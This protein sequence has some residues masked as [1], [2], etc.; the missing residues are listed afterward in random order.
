MP[1]ARF[2]VTG[3]EQPRY[4]RIAARDGGETHS[5]LLDG[6]KEGEGKAYFRLAGIDHSTDHSRGLWGYDDKGSE[7]LHAAGPRS[8]DRRG[9]GR[10]DREHRRRRRLGAGRQELLLYACWTK[11]TGRRRS[12]TT[13]SARRSREDRLVYEEEDPG[14]FMGVGGSLLDDFIYI[15][16]HDHETSEYRLLSTTDLTAEPQAGRR[17]ARPAS[18][19]R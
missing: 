14:F 15:D 13:S 16:I 2:F 8:R 7:Y 12:S 10:R 4:F 3:G 19:M 5:V 9:L 1:T 17:R 6:D 11:T 18:N